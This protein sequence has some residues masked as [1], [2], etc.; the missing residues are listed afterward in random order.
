MAIINRKTNKKIEVWKNLKKFL[1]IARNYKGFFVVLMVIAVI[2][3]L[4]HVLEKFLLKRVVDDAESFTNGLILKNA[5]VE[6]LLILAILF[7]GILLIKTFGRFYEVYLANR[8]NGS[9]TLE[10]RKKYFNHVVQLDNGFHTTHKTGSL[11]SKLMRGIGAVDAVGEFIIFNISPLI[12]YILFT[13]TAIFYFDFASAISFVGV[14]VAFIA[15]GIYVS[16]KQQTSQYHANKAQDVEIGTLSD[17]L[18]NID[19]VKY[20]G[21]EDEVGERYG[22][23]SGDTVS[24]M[25]KFWDVQAWFGAGTSLILGIGVLFSILFPIM[26]LIDGRISIGTLIFIYTMYGGMIGPLFGFVYGIKRFFISMGDM[27]ALFE[28]DELRNSIKDKKNA[29]DLDIKEGSL[30]FRNVSFRYHKNPVLKNASLEVKPGERVALV[31]YSGS[32][33]TTLVKLLYRFYNLNS[34]EILIDGKNINDFKQ[35][36]LR[37]EFSVVPQECILFDDTIY[38]NVAFSNPKASKIEVMKAMKFA[39]LDKFVAGLP[40]KEKTIVGERGVRLSGGEKQRVSIARAILANKKVLVLDEATSALDSKTEY[41]I[42]KDLEKLMEGRTSI[43]IA[44]RLS[45]IMKADKIVVMDKGRIV[46]MG[47]HR[48]L[49]NKKGVYK[50]LWNLQKGGYIEE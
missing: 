5:F 42:Q 33:K 15:F 34:G 6:T 40:K 24:K 9:M 29:P 21:K 3:E 28:Y 46:Q 39:Q 4:I 26:G 20:F 22:K 7:G 30:S 31:G 41:E 48:D 12:L 45:T 14:V 13:G 37:S 10:L 38:N 44:H 2:I 49:I 32:G 17:V 23:L 8:L 11:I 25:I 50:E 18:T 35:E 16:T 27:D 47:K 36:S 19:S 1:A 43:I